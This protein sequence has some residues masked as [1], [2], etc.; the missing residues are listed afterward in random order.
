MSYIL[1]ALRKSERERKRAEVPDPLAVQE[2]HSSENKAR[3]VRSHLVLVLVLVGTLI[4]GLWF[5]IWYAKRP[6]EKQSSVNQTARVFKEQQDDPQSVQEIQPAL[7]TE[8]SA[9]RIDRADAGKSPQ[10]NPDQKASKKSKDHLVMSGK[11]ITQN[12]ATNPPENALSPPEA[13]KDIPLPDKDRLYSLQ[14]LPGAMRQKLPDF[15]ISVFL[16]TDEH[17]SRS[18]RVNGVMMKEGQYIADGLKL[19]EIIPDGVIF[20]YM[21]YRFRVGIP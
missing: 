11:G 19:E 1:D 5:G 7:E 21:N 15:A 6:P 9:L 3:P 17:S 13:G 16:Y 8:R 20:S 18:V 14:E 2:P 12:S 4:S 10:E